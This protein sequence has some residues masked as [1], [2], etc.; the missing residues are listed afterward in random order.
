M[1]RLAPRASLQG[2]FDALCGVY[3][4][5]NA[6]Q[7]AFHSLRSSGTAARGEKRLT[8]LERQ[9]LFDTLMAALN[10]R[11]GAGTFVVNG[12][13]R[14]DLTRL[15]QAGRDWIFGNRTTRLVWRRC[16]YVQSASRSRV[17]ARLAQ[18]LATPGSAAIVAI[19]DPLPHWTVA[20]R[21]STTRIHLLDSG[22]RAFLSTTRRT[23][24]CGGASLQPGSIFL[25][26]LANQLETKAERP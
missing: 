6:T 26:S 3:S 12:I 8:T 16:L 7:W 5:I 1:K 22:G 11:R 23:R 10:E 25:L 13:G 18:H 4:V 21:V 19:D 24:R 15:L 9:A 14:R 2:E 20:T 17:L